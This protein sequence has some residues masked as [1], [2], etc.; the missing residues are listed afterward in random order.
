[1]NCVAE[2]LAEVWARQ[3]S[4]RGMRIIEPPKFLRYF[5]EKLDWV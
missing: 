2:A 3:E 5:T 4:I 1:M